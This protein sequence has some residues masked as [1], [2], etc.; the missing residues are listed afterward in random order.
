[1]MFGDLRGWI[2]HL[3][4]EGE[5]QEINAK[6]DW[7]CELGTIDRKAFEEGATS[8]KSRARSPRTSFR[9]G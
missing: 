9:G 7:D 3:R 1:M 6:V 8:I 5:L 2:D 4:N